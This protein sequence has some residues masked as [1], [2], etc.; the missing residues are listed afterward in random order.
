[1][2]S[3]SSPSPQ[4]SKLL[5][6]ATEKERARALSVA[7]IVR[8]T[9]SI[10]YLVLALALWKGAGWVQWRVYVPVLTIYVSLALVLY[11]LR[12]R[13]LSPR[14]SWLAVV[15]DVGALYVLQREAVE[16]SASPAAVAGF[17]AGIFAVLVALSAL[18]LHT[19]AIVLAF[20]SAIVAEALLMNQ[21]G[22][23]FSY[24]LCAGVIFALV[25]AMGHL[26]VRRLRLMAINLSQAE[27]KRQL[28]HERRTEVDARKQTIERMLADAEARNEQLARLQR[29]KDSLVQLIVHDL[30]S[31]LNAVMLSLDFATQEIKDAPAAGELR[32]ALSEAR[33]TTNRLSGMVTQILDT[34][35]LEEGRLVLERSPM[36]ARELLD[37]VRQQ[38][39]PM[40]RSKAVEVRVEAASDMVL[41][42]DPRLFGRVVENLLSNSIRHTPN[43]GRILLGATREG[44]SCRLS[45]HNSGDPIEPRDRD[46]IFAKFQQ[47]SSGPRLAGWGLG[48]YFCRMVVEAH[49]GTIVV[50]DVEGWPTSFV[51]RVPAEAVVT[52]EMA[53]LL[54]ALQSTKA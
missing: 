20:S 28:E 15:I 43:G 22:V 46:A 54:S 33:S 40:A 31:P 27:A 39:A 23:H 50:E 38:L 35:K 36:G 19:G 37:R 5:K 7:S 3:P 47:G 9:G 53:P 12:R 1:M 44:Q 34:A 26:S 14:I 18:T 49:D 42:G 52:R 21:A 29:E 13:P 11:L 41:R 10:A 45:V 2:S 25:G 4:L 30:R 16:V 32:E 8:I 6:E 51:V 48:L 24:T 17:S